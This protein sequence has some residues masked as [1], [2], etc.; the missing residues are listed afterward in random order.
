MLCALSL[1]LAD[2][3]TKAW[4]QGY[5]ARELAL[6]RFTGAGIVLLPLYGFF[7]MHWPDP[8]FW[9]WMLALVPLEITAMLL[10][11]HAIQNHP[12]SLTV[13][14]LSFSPVLATLNGYLLLDERVSWPGFLGI[15][16]IFIGGWLIHSKEAQG[17]GWRGSL[18]PWRAIAAHSGSRWMLVTALIYS[19][20]AIL[21][22][23]AMGNLEPVT[24]GA[25]YYQILGITV[26]ALFLPRQPAGI[27]RLFRSP[28]GVLA[29][30]G[31]SALM[32][33]THFMAISL[34]EAAYMISIKRT[35]LLFS[36]LLGI[37][38]FKEQ[39]GWRRLFA[40]LVMLGGIGCIAFA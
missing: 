23:G 13:P 20:T 40:G 8:G 24:F 26:L 30:M 28:R 32:V 31:C 39:E 12:L 9:W 21:S 7:P 10:Y 15:I 14:F 16:L 18:R 27:A 4:L 34:V 6:V 5:S 36:I 35:S 38:L 2:V 17:W 29:V 1:S 3:A 33:S 22:K 19:L 11:M 25:L 37:W